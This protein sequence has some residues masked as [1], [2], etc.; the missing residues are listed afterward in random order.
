MDTT[1]LYEKLLNSAD[2]IDRVIGKIP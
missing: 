1:C 2:Y